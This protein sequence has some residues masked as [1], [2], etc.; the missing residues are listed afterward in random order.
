[1]G[2]WY[3]VSKQLLRSETY[4]VLYEGIFGNRDDRSMILV[5]RGVFDSPLL[6]KRILSIG[7]DL[8]Y[9]GDVCILNGRGSVGNRCGGG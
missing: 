9:T 7:S 6:S 4:R 2:L 1:M 5:D 3:I 8:I